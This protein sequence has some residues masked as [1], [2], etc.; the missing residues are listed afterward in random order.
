M[1]TLLVISLLVCGLF[2]FA[3]S[4]QKYANHLLKLKQA[5][6]DQQASIDQQKS[7]RGGNALFNNLSYLNVRR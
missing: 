1:D 6:I 3:Q 2:T 7:N 4:S 5:L